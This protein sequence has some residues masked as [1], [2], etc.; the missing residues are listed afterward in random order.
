M[1]Y[2]NLPLGLRVQT[3]IP[4]DV[5]EY[6]LS[7]TAL[8]DLGA[9]D[10]LAYVYTQGLIVYCI[11]EQT[12]WEWREVVG[13]KTGL[14]PVNFTYPNGVI[15]FGINYSNKIFNFFPVKSADGSE[16]KIEAGDNVSISGDGTIATPYIINSSAEVSVPD[17]TAT[18]KGILKLTNDLG[19]TADLPT[20]PTA[21]HKTGNEQFTGIKSSTNNGPFQDSGISLINDGPS[22][23]YGLSVTNNDSGSGI[24]I[25]NEGVGYGILLYNNSTLQ[26]GLLVYST[27]EGDGIGSYMGE[28]SSGRAFYGQLDGGSGNIFEAVITAPSTGNTFVGK[29]YEDSSIFFKVDNVGNTTGKSFI[30]TGGL[31]TEYLM[32]NGSVKPNNPQKILLSPGGFTSGNYN[33]VD[34]DNDYVIFVDANGADVTI[35]V[36]TA[37]M[38]N[39]SCGFVQEG[40]GTVT[41]VGASNPIGP[42]MRGDGYQCFIEKKMNTAKWFLLGNVIP[43]P[44][45]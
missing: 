41:F 27:L 7:E 8:K 28:F 11:E 30:K 3:Q 18:V 17:A 16:T 1:D 14:L 12:R 36:T 10:N 24:L 45:P 40:T 5:K 38:D 2:V 9:G 15:T 37:T 29:K 33:L 21:L 32:A 23:T 4:L 44:T 39:F 25:A 19:G 22:T 42:T 31:I 6:S 20:T 34:S 13:A 35:N 43:T 26:E